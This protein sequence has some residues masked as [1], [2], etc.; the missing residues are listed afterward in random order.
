MNFV[1]QIK[2]KFQTFDT[3]GKLITVLAGTSILAWL[4]GLVYLR[5]YLQLVLPSGFVPPL[6]QPWSYI[7]HAFVHG[8]LWHFIGNAF[9]IFIAGRYILNLF[10]GRQ[11]LTL[12]FL[13]VLAGGLSFTLSTGLMNF[14]FGSGIAIGASGGVFA[15]M[16]F[17]CTYF[18]ESEYRLLFVNIKLKYIGYFLV[19]V[20]IV[21]LFTQFEAGASLAH[22]AGAAVGFY[23]AIRMK[24]GIDLLEGMAKVGDFFANL[25]KPRS[26]SRSSSSN[27]KTVYKNRK[28]RNKASTPKT[29]QAKLDAILDKISASGYESLSKAEKDYLFRAGKE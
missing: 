3:A 2:S 22:L 12:F 29:D 28:Q 21:G 13:G 8:S 16:L 27:M 25:F 1:D 17:A 24:D 4:I 6:L 9:G 14:Y 26:K 15:L 7:T 18:K 5:A 19:A 23:T 11:F 10:K 20:N